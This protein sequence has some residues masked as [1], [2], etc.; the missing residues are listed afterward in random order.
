[1]TGCDE[2]EIDK[3]SRH[4]PPVLTIDYGLYEHFLESAEIPED[5]KREFLAA[6]WSI[7]VE[8]VQLGF[9]VHP[10]QQAQKSGG[11]LFGTR[12]NSPKQRRR[13]LTSK[14]SSSIDF[15]DAAGGSLPQATERIQK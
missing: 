1:M 4:A 5:Q 14:D 10:A 3:D 2:T 7:I 11:Q 15:K 8:C 6:L 12:T 13:A 9:E